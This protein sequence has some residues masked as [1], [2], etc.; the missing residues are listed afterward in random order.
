[1]TA[2]VDPIVGQRARFVGMYDT[3]ADIDAFERHY[4]DVHI[5]LAKQYPS[6]RRYPR[7]DKP[8]AVIGEPC[9]MVVMLDRDDMAAPEAELGTEIGRRTAEDAAANP[10]RYATFRGMILQLDELIATAA[11]VER[12]PHHRWWLKRGRR[13][14][15]VDRTRMFRLAA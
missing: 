12:V 13:C 7:T 2:T 8:T 4:N 5:P 3:P 11:S 6:L 1:M 15:C 10:A 9:Y 14:L